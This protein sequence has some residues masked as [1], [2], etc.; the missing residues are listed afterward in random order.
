MGVSQA[1]GRVEGDKNRNLSRGAE[2]SRRARSSIK[3]SRY[4]RWRMLGLLRSLPSWTK[5]GRSW[6][7]VSSKSENDFIG[8]DHAL[9]L[10]HSPKVCFPR[11][12]SEKRTIQL[13]HLYFNDSSE[14]HW[15]GG[16]ASPENAASTLW[17]HLDNAK[18][19]N[20]VL[21]LPKTKEAKFTRLPSRSIPLIW[22][23]ATD[24]YSGA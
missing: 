6:S 20:A 3:E 18:P 10:F 21:S 14:Y 16:C 13:C 24:F 2:G 9:R 19:H 4:Y 1:I 7:D 5:G 11:N 12:T 23:P 8:K 15:K 17:V 22:Y